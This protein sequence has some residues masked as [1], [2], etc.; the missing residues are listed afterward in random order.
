[1][2]KLFNSKLKITFLG[3]GTSQGVPVIACH[4]RVCRNGK[5]KDKRLRSSVLIEAD[6]KIILID[7]GPDFR[8]QML[9]EKVERLDGIL[10]TH[11]HK[12]HIGGMDDVRSF[13]WL[14]KNAVDIYA[15]PVSQKVIMND[16]FYAFEENAY[17]GVP[18]YNLHT[19]DHQKFKVKGI[20]IEPLEALHLKMP[21]L[22]FRIGDFAYITDANY[23]PVS[24]LK[25]LVGCKVI[26]LSALRRE[27]HISHFNLEE[28]IQIME[29]LRPEKGYLTHVSHL[30][31]FHDETNAMLPDYIQLAY[32]RLTIEL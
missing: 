23:L 18:S 4:C 2:A 13:N 10:I 7:A 21:V 20:E 32:D 3:T 15:T 8:Y 30:M 17:P 12:D 1:L 26:V 5:E 11:H 25:K 19:I 31:G 29:F 28:A 9:R 22:G 14:T 6:N 27:K 16:F 24:T